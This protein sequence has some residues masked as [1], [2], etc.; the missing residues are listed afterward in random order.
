MNSNS[1]SKCYTH[2][3]GTKIW[4][5]NGKYHRENG[6]AIDQFDGYKAWY[7]HGK[8]HREDGPARVW[9]DGICYWY[10]NGYE[11]YPEESVKSPELLLEYPKLIESM[12]IYLVHN[13]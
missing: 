6:P 1:K 7:F 5:L 11:Y 8:W 3:N 12:I 10:I 9:P 2:D 4:I 13:S